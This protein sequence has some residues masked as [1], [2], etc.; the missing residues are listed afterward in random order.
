MAFVS[1]WYGV[2]LLTDIYWSILT[3][4][5]RLYLIKLCHD[6]SVLLDWL[7]NTVLGIFLIRFLKDVSVD[8]VDIYMFIL[9]IE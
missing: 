8:Y 3:C 6:I 4:Q 7:S 5:D 9:I 1:W 2:Q